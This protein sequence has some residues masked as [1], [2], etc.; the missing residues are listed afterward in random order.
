MDEGADR[1]KGV[2]YARKFTC[3][4]GQARP[5]GPSNAALYGAMYGGFVRGQVHEVMTALDVSLDPG[6]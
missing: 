1:T 6:N 2:S 5:L 3:I 4:E